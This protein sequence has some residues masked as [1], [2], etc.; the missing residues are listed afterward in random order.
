MIQS[1]TGFARLE[2]PCQPGISLEIKAVNSRYLDLYCRLPDDLSGLEVNIRQLAK[3]ALQ[4]GKVEISL[5]PNKGQGQQ[6]SLNSEALQHN[7]ALV[8]QLEQQMQ[9]QGLSSR[10]ISPL[11]LLSLPGV[12]SQQKN[13]WSEHDILDY[14][15]KGLAQ[16]VQAR[17]QEG[18]ALAEMLSERLQQIEQLAQQVRARQPE[19][20]AAW[21][22]RLRQRIQDL[23]QQL[24]E[25]RL[26]QE[27]AVLAQKADI[28]EEL[29]RLDTHI[30]ECRRILKA[31]GACGRKLDFY[32]QEF[33]REANTLASKALSDDVTAIAVEIKVLI[34]QMREQVQ[35]IE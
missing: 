32:M 23:S 34:E 11:E 6:A 18:Q 31:G 29:D 3:Q 14:V 5:L 26:Q 21:Q 9:L 2:I 16:L 1:M 27:V 10:A 13:D 22:Q 7:L 33:N 25:Q 19:L 35:N 17:Q 15:A 12:L 4:R 20:L 28:A 30:K 8:Q 24:D